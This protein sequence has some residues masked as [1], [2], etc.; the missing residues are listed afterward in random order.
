MV[1]GFR[2]V[3]GALL[4]C[5][6]IESVEEL[7]GNARQSGHETSD[8]RVHSAQHRRNENL[9][10]GQIR[11]GYNT[12]L[13]Q[14]LAVKNPAFDLGFLV[15]LDEVVDELREMCIRDRLLPFCSVISQ[16]QR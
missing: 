9:A 7:L 4:L 11:Q 5:N 10:A 12:L 6:G 1:A 8:R 14:H 15:L 13:I 2:R 16:F 3:L